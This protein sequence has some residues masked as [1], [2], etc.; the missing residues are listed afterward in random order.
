MPVYY[1]SKRKNW[2]VVYRIKDATGKEKQS[3]KRGFPKKRDAKAWESEF[4]LKRDKNMDMSF[5]SLCEIYLEYVDSNDKPSTYITNENII[6]NKI[7]PYFKDKKVSE[8]TLNDVEAWHNEMIKSGIY[9]PSYL[10][11][12]H[13]QLS[14][15]FNYAIKHYNLKN[16]PAKAAGTMGSKKAKKKMIIWDTEEYKKF[17]FEIMDKPIY[18]Y[19]F[20]ML[21]WTGIRLGELLALT[22]SDFDFKN[23]TVTIDK[24]LQHIKGRDIILPPKTEKSERTISLPQFLSEEMKEYIDS[25]YKIE[26][27]ERI[28]NISK[29]S[30]HREMTRGSKASGVKRIPIHHLRHSHISLLIHMGYTAV[31][32]GDRVG[33]ESAYITYHYAHIFQAVKREIAN[34]LDKCRN[35]EV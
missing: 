29:S 6:N 18:F 7:L 34:N 19:A 11:E 28:F 8:I 10:R 15:I 25:L 2:Y 33:H 27:S 16:N 1:D 14:A 3:T 21:Y 26:N 20:E 31:D 22:P 35:Q 13:S 30:L 5:Q 24:N 9:A 32:I 12:M 17:S 23:H 4:N